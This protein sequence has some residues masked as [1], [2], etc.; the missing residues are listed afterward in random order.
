MKTAECKFDGSGGGKIK[1]T[2]EIFEKEKEL[3]IK[4]TLTGFSKAD[5]DQVVEHGF[6]VHEKGDLDDQCKASGGHFNPASQKHGAPA[7][8]TRHM[9]DLG[10]IKS[11][12]NQ[13][14]IHIRDKIA[15]LDGDDSVT[16]YIIY[17]TFRAINQ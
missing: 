14:K 13:A 3:H 12:G 9:G 6:H 17:I 16:L 2:V 4:G 10:N 1:G 7:D 5:D 8:V 15:L 11:E